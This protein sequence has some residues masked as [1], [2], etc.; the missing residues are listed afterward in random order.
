MISKKQE[1]FGLYWNRDIMYMSVV[2]LGYS[3]YFYIIECFMSFYQLLIFVMI[4]CLTQD[5]DIYNF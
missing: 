1:F 5:Y 3:F 4:Y 2:I